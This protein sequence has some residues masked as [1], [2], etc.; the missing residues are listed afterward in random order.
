M[1]PEQIRSKGVNG[2]V[3][4]LRCICKDTFSD[5]FC[6]LEIHLPF[7]SKEENIPLL[8]FYTITREQDNLLCADVCHSYFK[9]CSQTA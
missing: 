4:V 1:K 9:P 7:K 2:D 5:T 6:L 8:W 3:T